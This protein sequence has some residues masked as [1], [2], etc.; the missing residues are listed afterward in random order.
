MRRT[1]SKKGTMKKSIKLNYNPTLSIAENAAK[2]GCTV[3]AVRSY[4][5]R[6]GIDR[7]RDAANA[8]IAKIKK[9]KEENPNISLRQ[10]AKVCGMSFATIKKYSAENAL[11]NLTP[12]KANQVIKSVGNSQQEILSNIIRL[13]VHGNIECDLTYSVG[14]FYKGLEPP[15][16]KFDKFPQA[17]EVKPLEEAYLMPKATL[18]S[19]V[20]DLPFLVGS[21][22]SAKQARLNRGS[23]ISPI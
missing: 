2:C 6:S 23:T 18:N 10:L 16:F 5:K 11:K 20:I 8:R 17:N 4:I 3:W 14:G 21:P 22:Q 19:V 12:N 13:Y 1:I 15:K 7:K 9:V